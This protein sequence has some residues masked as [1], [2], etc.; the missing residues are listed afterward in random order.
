M[1]IGYKMIDISNKNSSNRTAC[2]YGMINVGKNIF[3]KI[4]NNLIEKGNPI[5]LAKIAGIN[6]TKKTSYLIPLCHQINIENAEIKIN[7]N[8]K[9]YT[10]EVYSIVTAFSKT[11]VEIEALCSTMISLLTIY[12]LTKKY[13]PMV[14]IKKIKMIFKNGGKNGLVINCFNKF[15]FINY[16]FKNKLIINFKKY[17]CTII[18]LSDRNFFGKYKNISGQIMLDYLKMKCLNILDYFTTPDNKNIIDKFLKTYIRKKNPNLLFM[19]G[20]TGTNKKDITN[21]ILEKLCK[22]KITGLSEFL[23]LNNYKF[24]KYS[25]LSSNFFGIYKKTILISI[26]G[27]PK[28]IFESLDGLNEMLIHLIKIYD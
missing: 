5:E 6:A 2:A 9:N 14:E 12:D 24:S 3:F 4:K 13:N 18:T 15:K 28:S 23:R 7:L 8:K 1:M 22:K 25:W 16:F 20:G 21:E 19:T 17:T 26:S 10:I 27:N 11:G